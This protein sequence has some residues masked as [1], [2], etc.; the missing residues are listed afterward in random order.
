MADNLPLRVRHGDVF[1]RQVIYG[2]PFPVDL[3]GST[4][5]W[6]IAVGDNIHD[7]T[8]SPQVVP[9]TDLSTGVI[10]LVLSGTETALFLTGRGRYYFQVI[11]AGGEPSTIFIGDVLVD[12]NE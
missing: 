8:G 6:H 1:D 2:G 3:T 4:F 7:Y 5:L 9:D 10:N 12:F 11:S